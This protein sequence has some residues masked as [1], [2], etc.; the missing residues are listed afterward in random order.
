MQER[1]EA[2][3][4]YNVI[5]QALNRHSAVREARLYKR[6]SQAG[7]LLLVA[8]IVS[9]ERIP[10]D[11]LGQYLENTLPDL[12]RPDFY[13][14]L[15]AMPYTDEGEVDTKKLFALPLL[16]GHMQSLWQRALADS[17]SIDQMAVME[18]DNDLAVSGYHR[19]ELIGIDR[20]TLETTD[21]GATLQSGTVTSEQSTGQIASRTA[22]G[23]AT[24]ESE[25]PEAVIEGETLIATDD[26]PETLAEMLLRAVDQFPEHGVHYIAA[27][28]SEYFQSY[29]ELYNAAQQRLKGLYSLG[30]KQGDK[31]IFQL[32]DN[33]EF[34]ISFWA[35]IFGGLVP[36]PVSI[37][38]VYLSSNAV[39]QKLVNT[40]QLLGEAMILTSDDLLDEI[41]HVLELTDTSRDKLQS[42]SCLKEEGTLPD[43]QIKA[44]DLT[45]LLLT[46]GSTGMPKA[47]MH[48]HRTL[49]GRSASAQQMNHVSSDDISLNWM[50]L[51]HVGG[52]VMHNIGDIYCGS[53]QVHVATSWVLEQPLRWLELIDRYRASITWAPNFS[54]ALVVENAEEI[55]RQHWDLSS[56]RLIINGGEPVVAKT[57]KRFLAVLAPH[58]LPATCMFPVWG[59][60]ETAS[61]SIYSRDFPP[62]HDKE[63]DRFVEIGIPLPDMSIR[64][65]DNQNRLLREGEKGNLQVKGSCITIGYFNNPEEN[66][67]AFTDDGWFDTGDAGFVRDGKLTLTARTKDEIIINGVNYP[68]EE[69]EA[70]VDS[71]EGTELTFSVAC[72]VRAQGDDTDELAVFF[73]PK[74]LDD[75]EMTR[76]LS[77]INLHISTD[78]GITPDYIVPLQKSQIP[79][80]N[81]GKI[82]HQ[83]V[84]QGFEQG[85]FDSA[86]I[87]AERLMSKNTIPDWFYEKSWYKKQ[88]VNKTDFSA[89]GLSLI[90]SDNAGLANALAKSLQ[91]NDLP[92][93]QV[94]AGEQFRRVN[95]YQYQIDP[96]EP[97][98]YQRLLSAIQQDGLHIKQVI[99]LFCYQR[100]IEIDNLTAF[101][102]AQSYGV[103]SLLALFKALTSGVLDENRENDS[104]VHLYAVSNATFPV[105]KTDT[106]NGQHAA[107]SG[108]L[109]SATLEQALI[110]SRHIDLEHHECSDVSVADNVTAILNELLLTTP[111]TDV[112]YRQKQRYTWKLKRVPLAEY[113]TQIAPIKQGGIYLI[114]GGLGGIGA[115]VAG[116]LKKQYQ[117]KIILTGRTPLPERN[118]WTQ[119]LEKNDKLAQR[120]RQYL[121]IESL[122]GEL[123]YQAVDAADHKGITQLVSQQEEQWGESL[124]GIIHL[125]A[126]GDVSS[127]WQDVESHHLKNESV[128]EFD[129]MYNAKIYGTLAL[130]K[131]LDERPAATFICFSSVIGLFGGAGFGAYSSAHTFLDEYMQYLHRKHTHSYCFNWSVWEHIGRSESDP[132]FA[133]DLYQSSGYFTIPKESGMDCL[134]AGLSHQHHQ[135]IVGL[136]ASKQNI[137]RYLTDEVHAASKLQAFYTIKA[138]GDESSAKALAEQLEADSQTI[139]IRDVLDVS[140]QCE[141]KRLHDMPLNNQGEPDLQALQLL[142]KRKAEQD[143]EFRLPESDIE[144][145]IAAI[146]REILLTEKLDAQNSFFLLGGNSLN[147]TQML[148]RIREQ[149]H[150]QMEMRDRFENAT[151]EQMANIIENK[152]QNK[153]SSE[154]EESA[155]SMDP[156]ILLANI[157]NMSDS[158]VAELLA[159]LQS[160]EKE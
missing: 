94:M 108:L 46:S 66:K 30:L 42:V 136:D 134:F 133:R 149:F 47:V 88:P 138:A 64:I 139:D 156:E 129:N 70:I 147:A 89:L 145:Q 111:D 3:Q 14:F 155:V 5:E 106:A 85:K 2:L 27:D 52:V 150:I 109:K 1:V 90:F 123:I 69:I 75:A 40:W 101:K 115:Y 126:A 120:I 73:C 117:A 104:F 34:M 137:S 80:T 12:P 44:D 103:F 99:H 140:C 36:V 151:I 41:S 31:V 118:S 33:R 71:I 29:P 100:D 37:A 79:K 119:Y 35:C 146:W 43:I 38:P 157:D 124:S 18:V 144:K 92:V 16:N 96:S 110:K 132:E 28:G 63:N 21:S 15:S 98:H 4:Q 116:V 39:V 68:A 32:P 9:S 121:D 45:L 143:T 95:T 17:G 159:K 48:S 142:D 91:S 141:L 122:G 105:T 84:K 127:H 128:S 160:E 19:L 49:L 158:Q 72:A 74:A 78:I 10:S 20:H 59:M 23:Q 7:D 76:V 83:Q 8:Y 58:Q 107:I 153:S 25:M 22:A 26:R 24:A 53:T 6:Q 102:D 67:K 60:S 50:P 97:E 55:A 81:I 152:I 65:V 77:E 87:Y 148:T 56:M 54:Y 113:T 112:A 86:L 125:A 82:Q 11:T 131:L 61:G 130:S 13:Q 93:V 57:A 51:D 154:A 135:L 62:E 114:S